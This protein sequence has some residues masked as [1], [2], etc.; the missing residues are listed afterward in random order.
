MAHR[1]ITKHAPFSFTIYYKSGKSNLEAD[2]L[3]RVPWDKVIKPD[4]VLAIIKA[5]VKGLKALMKVCAC[6]TKAMESV[7]F[8]TLQSQMV[9]K[10]G[11]WI[12]GMTYM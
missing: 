3:S 11:Y 10:I 6:S 2:S 1:W 7:L 8:D 5:A 12:R 9:M 4:T